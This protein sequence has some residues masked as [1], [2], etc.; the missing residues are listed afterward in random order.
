VSGPA[1]FFCESVLPRTAPGARR[2]PEDKPRS[3]EEP[4]FL[5]RFASERPCQVKSFSFSISAAAKSIN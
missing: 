2:S 5:E 1:F 3:A 4:V